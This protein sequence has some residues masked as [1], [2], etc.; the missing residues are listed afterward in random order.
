MNHRPSRIRIARSALTLVSASLC[1]GLMTAAA[2]TAVASG[3]PDK[4]AHDSGTLRT[5]YRQ[6]LDVVSSQPGHTEYRISQLAGVVDSSS[7]QEARP[8]SVSPMNSGNSCVD[9]GSISVGV[10]ETLTYDSYVDSGTTYGRTT[11][12]Q[13]QALRYDSQAKLDEIEWLGAQKG[14]C[15]SSCG[16]FGSN[17]D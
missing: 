17:W 10:C 13:N 7:P 11:K 8:P 5:V 16:T 6:T 3:T 12:W 4:G 2:P 1:L 15:K 14:L 9:D